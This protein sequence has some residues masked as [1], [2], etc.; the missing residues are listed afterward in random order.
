MKAWC[1]VALVTTEEAT[2]AP[3]IPS[4]CMRLQGALDA[5]CIMTLLHY[6]SD[7]KSKTLQFE[8]TASAVSYIYVYGVHGMENFDLGEVNFKKRLCRKMFI[9]KCVDKRTIYIIA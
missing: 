9:I 7:S 6:S 8:N 1:T 3:P 4:P 5:V 2:T